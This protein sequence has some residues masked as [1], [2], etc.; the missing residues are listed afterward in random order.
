M[1]NFLKRLLNVVLLPFLL[2]IV[3]CYWC[4]AFISLA[5][6]IAIAPA[7]YLFT[8]V[9]L[10]DKWIGTAH[11]IEDKFLEKIYNL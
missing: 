10:I 11:F 2:I 6:T 3:L 8:G 5:I 9:E 1:K 4:I 7:V